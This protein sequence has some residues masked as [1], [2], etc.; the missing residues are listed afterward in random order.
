M[1]RITELEFDE[2]NEGKLATHHIAAAEVLQI[3][4]NQFT[5]RRNKKNRT[6]ARQLIGVTNGGRA[7]TIILAPTRMAERWRPIT[8]WDSTPAERR[9]L[10]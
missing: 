6:G 8:G 7:L 10:Q 5:V 3:L 1:T 2:D 4:E 9:F